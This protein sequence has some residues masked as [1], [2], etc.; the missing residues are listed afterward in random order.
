MIKE[1][2]TITN[3]AG[4]GA[5]AEGDIVVDHATAN[6]MAVVAAIDGNN[7]P[8]QLKV[9]KGVFADGVQLDKQAD[10]AINC[11]RPDWFDNQGLIREHMG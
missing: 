11:R 3:A 5:F 4:A 9:I 2:H 7:R 1:N 10:A 8:T 6:N